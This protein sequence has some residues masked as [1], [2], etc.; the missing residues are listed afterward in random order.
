MCHAVLYYSCFGA[1][2]SKSASVL[3]RF[4][5]DFDVGV[6]TANKS[7]ALPDFVSSSTCI[8]NCYPN[9][10]KMMRIYLTYLTREGQEHS[11]EDCK[12]L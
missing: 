10:W 11:V 5:V 9:Y 2:F 6:Q 4:R 12:G 3:H 7:T 8:L 1:N